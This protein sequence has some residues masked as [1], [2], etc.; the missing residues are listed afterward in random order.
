MLTRTQLGG[1]PS[2]TTGEEVPY[3]RRSF[4]AGYAALSF[5]NEDSM[6]FRH[7]LLGLDPTWTETRQI[8]AHYPGLWPGYYTLEVQASAVSGEWS[9]ETARSSFRIL[10]PWWL[11]WWAL[12]ADVLLLLLTGRLLWAWRVRSILSRQNELERAVEDRTRKLVAEQQHAME[13]KTRA[14]QEKKIVEAQ[15]VEIERLLHDSRQA[16]RVKSEFLANISH[17]VRTPLNGIMGMTELVLR[18]GLNDDQSDCLRLVKSSADGLLLVIN[19]VLDFSKIGK[20]A[21]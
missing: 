1:T 16:E 11:T 13:E 17:E 19:D 14:E 8:E 21:N 5:V 7:R 12:A 4:D 2:S 18:S 20:P 3:S 6:R 9:A 10:P 15:K